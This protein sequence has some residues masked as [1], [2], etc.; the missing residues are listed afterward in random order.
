[1]LTLKEVYYRYFAPDKILRHFTQHIEVGILGLFV[2]SLITHLTIN[3]KTLLIFFTFTFVPDLDGISSVFIWQFSNETAKKIID[4]LSKFKVREALSLAT[5]E[6][7][8]LNKLLIHN[9]VV[10]PVLCIL[11]VYSIKSG[12]VLAYTILAAMVT[13]FLFD[14]FDDLYQ[15]GHIK[16]WLWPFMYIF[17]QV[18]FFSQDSN[19]FQTMPLKSKVPPFIKSKMI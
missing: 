16:N 8:K 15:L 19:K 11:F 9:L 17:P 3:T 18:D 2:L 4:L 1:M 13:H 6:H 14:I 10:F 5:V 7:K 12:G